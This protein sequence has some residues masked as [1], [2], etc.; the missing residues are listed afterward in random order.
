M[1]LL[2]CTIFF[3]LYIEREKQT[4]EMGHVFGYHTDCARGN[5]VW[6]DRGKKFFKLE[7]RSVLVERVLEPC[8]FL[9]L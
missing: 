7:G 3:Y 8:E 2:S 1:L 6:I 4:V 5:G 9:R